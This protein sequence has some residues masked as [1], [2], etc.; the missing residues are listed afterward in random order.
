MHEPPA[1]FV[2]AS[3]E[4]I[5]RQQFEALETC[6]MSQCVDRDGFQRASAV[7][8]VPTHARQWESD[9]DD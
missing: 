3:A 4:P 1:D 6:G 7:V 5:F 9:L 8:V 2:R